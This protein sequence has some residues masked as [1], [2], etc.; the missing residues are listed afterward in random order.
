M[1]SWSIPVMVAAA[2]AALLF[3]IAHM[4][5][6]I[7]ITHWARRHSRAIFGLSLAVYC[8]SWTFYGAVGTALGAGL[9]YLPIYLGPIV[10]FLFFPG[11]VSRVVEIG[12]TQHSTSIAD[13][14]SARYGKS[15]WVAALVTLIALFG[16]LPYMALQLKSVSQTLVALSPD[17]TRYLHA[18]EIV[19]AVAGTM[20]AFAV[21]FGTGRLDLTQHNRGMVLAI[22]V[23]A[24]VKLV[25][26]GSVALLA[27]YLLLSEATLET[28][29]QRAGD[30][31]SFAQIDARFVTLTFLAAMA[32][33]CLPRQFH[34]LVVEAQEDRLRGSMR[35]LFP[36]YLVIICAAVVPV[37][38]A[39][40]LLM[41][42]SQADMLVLSL[43]QTFG[44][45]LLAMLAFIGGFSASTG[46]IIVT[47]I[48]LSGMITNDLIL[49]LFFRDR[50][51]QSVDRQ[52]VGPVLI[53][54]RRLTIIGLLAF[55][56]FYV[57]AASES[58]SL[59][60]LGEIAFA[61]VAQF[62][63]GLLLGLSW[64][65]AN[66]AGMIAG[67]LGGFVAWMVLLAFP[68]FVP[69]SLPVLIGDD[70]LVSGTI[71]SLGINTALFVLF[72]LTSETSLSDRV[73][74]VAF[75]DRQA[76][77]PDP[78]D[79]SREVK[80]ADFRL[81]MEQFVGEERTREALNALRLETGRNYRDADR[82]D[83]ALRNACERM[84]SAIIGSSSAKALI[85]STL[86]GESVSLEHVVAMFDE[87]TQRLQF[88]AGL[89]Q[90]AIENIDQGISVVDNEQRLV[91]WN[92]RY[93]EMFDLPE[94]LVEVGRPIADL[95]RF[96]MRSLRFPEDTIDAEV[97]KRLEYLRQGSRHST[98]RVLS[99]GRI[100]R[101]LGNPA[102]NGGYVTSYTDVTADRVAEQA[103]EAKVYE[104]TEQ[105]VQSNAA[106]EAATRSKTR[107]LAAASHD[108]VQPLNAARLFASALSEEIDTERGREQQLLGQIDRSIRTADR[109]LR[110][111]LDISRLDGSKVDVAKS[112]FS[113]DLAFAEIRNEFEVQAEAKGVEL[114]VQPCGLWIETDRGL[115][116]SVLQNLVTNAVRYTDA[117]KV[118]IGGKRRGGKVQIVVADQG[119]GIP[120]QDLGRIF[121]EFTQLDRKHESEGLGLGLAIVKR[122][123]AMLGT[124]VVVESEPGVG[125]FFSFRMPVVE[126]GEVQT[127][128]E[129]GR[130]QA[131]PASGAR[132][133]CIDNDR[134]SC[135]GIVALLQRWGLDAVG[136]HHPDEAPTDCA[137]SLIVLDYRLDDGLTGDNACPVLE[138]KFGSLPPIIL[139][140]AE[141]TE[142]T[143][144]AAQTI[145][146][147]RLIKP[148]SPAILRAL[149]G[150]L[151]RIEA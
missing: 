69:E 63:P 142:E 57:R 20:A 97:S 143:K 149:I 120:Q 65:R 47:S 44:F 16:A 139:L 77:L 151:L 19:M 82:A 59:A 91:A 49:P 74:A 67:L 116:V 66:R 83:A 55:A 118:L 110:A 132:V 87:T 95:L 38:V 40:S 14:L 28:S 58:L 79:I 12:K 18:D 30:T 93:V 136:A 76:A 103:L 78:G 130:G 133:L 17:I 41:P 84:I 9:R 129:E 53:M 13:F 31:F 107:F 85:Q 43:P 11:F 35:W 72:S 100:L 26:L 146:A 36:L 29:L 61:G 128:V 75:V 90:I 121:E 115:F 45:D 64:R 73:Q 106:L 135:E 1:S 37:A 134:A 98:E 124:Q 42:G 4:G 62:A 109:L 150:S 105:L 108:L 51:R 86:E 2:Y 92:S 6:R 114:I 112:R 60:G 131:M 8:T 125:S 147:H 33:L 68:V 24:M 94:E 56:Y 34:M 102:P 10:L 23:E 25:A 113:L 138:E 127:R 15:A 123:A 39:G 144:L 21:L 52:N 96:N 48:A 22:A 145:G 141:E 117:G 70:A 88:G 7:A 27:T 104:R 119:P 5:D 32:V 122:I 148:A 46:M 89:L 50:L 71:I 54:V 101:V 111:L 3:W 80:V 81:L 137:P 126:P 140:T 99:D